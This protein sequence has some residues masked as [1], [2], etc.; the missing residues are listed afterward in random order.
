MAVVEPA[1]PPRGLRREREL[2][3][4]TGF[5]PE[6]AKMIRA[7]GD[8]HVVGDLERFGKALARRHDVE[9]ESIAA[10][11]AAVDWRH[12][13][14]VALPAARQTGHVTQLVLPK[15]LAHVQRPDGVLRPRLPVHLDVADV[16]AGN[17]E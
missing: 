12:E 13:V 4:E 3:R 10:L 17:V 11:Q 5:Q 8:R 7:R 6:S 14:A 16:H 2:L 1:E 9:L 15:A